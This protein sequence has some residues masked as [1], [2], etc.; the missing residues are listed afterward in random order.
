MDEEEGEEA[1][2]DT[3]TACGKTAMGPKP[4]SDWSAFSRGNKWMARYRK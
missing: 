3:L 2:M 1:G 4:F